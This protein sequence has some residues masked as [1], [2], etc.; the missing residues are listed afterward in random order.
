MLL[1]I[2]N[3]RQEMFLKRYLLEYLSNKQRDEE[4]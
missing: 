4:E 3:P 2:D 1:D